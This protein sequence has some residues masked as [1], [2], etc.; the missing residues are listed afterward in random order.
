[1]PSPPVRPKYRR[2]FSFG[3]HMQGRVH[4]G[5]SG[6]S[7]AAG[8]TIWIFF[9]NCYDGVAIDNANTLRKMLGIKK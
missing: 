7:Y 6:W 3:H 1:M 8:Q 5:I 4:I 9:N 2:G